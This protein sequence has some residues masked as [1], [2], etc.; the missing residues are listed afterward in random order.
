MSAHTYILYYQL[1]ELLMLFYLQI[2][3]ILQ[4]QNLEREKKALAC[5]M[6]FFHLFVPATEV[7]I[8][9]KN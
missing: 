6:F 3:L 5:C 7:K 2:L 8:A 1:A 9:K 4:I